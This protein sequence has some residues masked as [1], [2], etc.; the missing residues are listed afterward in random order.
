M[1]QFL[2]MEKRVAVIQAVMDGV[3]RLLRIDEPQAAREPAAAPLTAPAKETAIITPALSPSP[4]P[5]SRPRDERYP[6]GGGEPA[7]QSSATAP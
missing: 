7:N 2:A 4:R 1:S 3:L 5:R 6:R